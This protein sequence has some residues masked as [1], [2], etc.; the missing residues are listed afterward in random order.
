M[1]RRG[2]DAWFLQE[3]RCAALPAGYMR[4]LALQAQC[5][6]IGKAGRVEQSMNS[7]W[8]ALTSRSRRIGRMSRR[9]KENVG[10]RKG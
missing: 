4:N 7:P 3:G 5:R 1:N 9:R 6:R 8:L 10:K 2:E